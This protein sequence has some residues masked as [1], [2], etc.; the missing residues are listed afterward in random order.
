MLEDHLG[1]IYREFKREI[2]LEPDVDLNAIKNVLH[3]GILTLKI[4]KQN[5]PDGMGS[6]SNSH[7]LHS[8]NGF[9]EIYTDDGK[10]IK[11]TSDFSG[12]NPENVK[13]VLSA[14]NVLKVT[15]QQTEQNLKGKGSIQKEVTRHYTLP[16]WV[17][18]ENMKAIMSRDGILNVDIRH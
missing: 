7:N 11:L 10:L 5:R 9:K 16:N 6:L 15:A 3:Q 18:P 14:N 13:I 8:P 17:Q 2:H 1:K 12:Y 4:P